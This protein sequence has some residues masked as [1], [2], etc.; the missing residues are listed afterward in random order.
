MRR[1]FISFFCGILIGAVLLGKGSASTTELIAKP[2]WH[3]FYVD[4]QEVQMTAYNIAGNNY[5]RLRDIGERVGFNVYWLDGVQIDSGAPYTGEAPESKASNDEVMSLDDIRLEM[6]Q[7]INR[8][9]KE[10]GVRELT[11]DE[12]LMDA[13]QECASWRV[14]YHQT[15]K[16]C[17]AVLNSGYPHGFVSNLTAFTATPADKIA[18]HAVDNWVHSP[19]HFAA[20]I[21]AGCDTIGVGVSDYGGVT[22]CYMLAG[23]PTTHNPYE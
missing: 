18:E 11:I 9:R 21:E 23:N 15:Q 3:R 1:L 20:M 7:R 19:G 22:I 8:V 12:S 4:G 2:S 6:V 16:E 10:N 13:A 17:E 5:V 14:T